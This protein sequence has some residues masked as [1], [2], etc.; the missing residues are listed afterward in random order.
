MTTS[1]DEILKRGERI[2][3]LA[4]ITTILLAVFKALVGFFAG[5]VLLVADAVH[6]A[7]DTVAIFSSWFGLKISQ[8][9]YTEK[10]P[11]G[12][13]KAENLAT[14]IASL[15]ILYASYGIFQ[16]SYAKFFE[17]TNLNIP[18]L[19]MFVPL[20][21]AFI[22]YFIAHYERKVGKEINSQS[23]IA[24]AEESRIDIFSS[25][26][27]FVGILLS[28]FQIK[29]VE[30]ILGIGLSLMILKIGLENAKIAIYSLMDANLDKVLEEQISKSMR[31]IKGVRKLTNLKLR[32][33]GLFVFA[34]AEIQLDKNLNVDQAH[35][36]ADDIENKIKSKYPKIQNLTLHIEPFKK[37]DFKI[38]IPV[39]EDGDDLDLKTI[40]HF[41]RAKYFLFVNLK[42]KKI[43]SSYTKENIY[44][45]K[46]VRSGLSA[47]KEA[48][49]ENI[50][51]VITKRIGEISFHTLHDALVDVYLFDGEKASEAIQNFL[52]GKLEKLEKA[53]H[54]SDK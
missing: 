30:G 17:K 50:D 36:I 10:F 6:S 46:E 42:N 31:N 25:L 43:I 7:V 45:Q 23:L 37:N 13:F 54:E 52:E 24:N 27:V 49:K 12:Y 16:E 26:M 44:S 35:E 19:A 48:L 29:Y 20:F 51:L 33:A 14:L 47:A 8:K 28:Y 21:S 38:L 2:A 40:N 22:S 3:K 53:T 32:Q 15:F 39:D 11:Y 34:E 18:F 9:K 4:T 41:G 1:K 5:S